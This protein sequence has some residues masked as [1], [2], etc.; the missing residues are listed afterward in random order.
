MRIFRSVILACPFVLAA[1]PLSGQVLTSRPASN[2]PNITPATGKAPNANA[3]YQQLR[4]ASPSGEISSAT[5]LV[6]KRDAGTFSFR[7]G[8]FYFLTPVNGKVTGAVFVGDGS[9]TLAHHWP[10]RRRASFC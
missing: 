4:T 3:M 8:T 2:T 9:F 10:W 1:I 7:S 6:L 5:N